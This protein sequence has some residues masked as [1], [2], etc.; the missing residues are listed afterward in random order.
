MGTP[1]TTPGSNRDNCP[2]ISTACV[3]W[4]GPDIPC[5]DLCAGDSIDEVVFKLATLLCDVTENILDITTLEFACFIQSGVE[6]PQNL[7]QLLQLIINKICSLEANGGGTSFGNENRNSGDTGTSTSD[8]YVA[9]PPCLYF[10]DSNGDLVTTMLFTDYLL[11]LAN[12]ICTVILDIN[13]INSNI[14]MLTNNVSTL[15][16][17][18]A[19]LQAYTYEIF[20]TSQC[21][22]APTPGQTLLIQDAFANLEASYCNMLSSVGISTILFAAVNRQCPSL[23]SSPVLFG[24]GLMGDI[25]EWVGTP[26]T[27]ADAINNLWLTVCDMRN[28]LVNYFSL[29]VAL[30]CV[31][32]VPENV[33]AMTIGTAYSTITWTA[34]SYAGI[35]LPLTYR[36]EVF[37]WTGSAPT[38]PS[39]FDSVVSNSTFSVNIVGSSIVVG[40]E[41]V[42]YIHA[43][44]SCGESNGAPIVTE[45]LVPT[46]LFHINVDDVAAPDTSIFCTESALPVAYTEKNNKT[47]VQLVNAVS[48]VPVINGNAY[49]IEVKIRY[50]VTS[51]SFYGT[52]YVDVIIP[53]IP[54]NSSANYVYAAGTYNNCGTALCTPVNTVLSC[55]VSVNDINT[56]FN[57]ANTFSVCV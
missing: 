51:C 16:F 38:G 32:A 3:I 5:I 50:A 39:L 35:E 20:V 23:A 45:L 12:T 41:Y 26:T 34:P 52:S 57:P 18:V 7:K 36:I 9:L 43:G 17:Q 28:Q 47:T 14:L 31:L 44:Y 49:N 13:N 27:A 46:I 42:V 25:P 22:S 8:T 40:T 11:Y 6:D 54:G 37:E 33:T 10:T 1:I 21:A 48:G 29:P 24:S 56:E 30:P 19:N 15:Q 53:I 2:K 55:Q 4:Q